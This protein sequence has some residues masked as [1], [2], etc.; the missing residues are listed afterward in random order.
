LQTGFSTK[1]FCSHSFKKYTHISR[2]LCH[3]KVIHYS[4]AFLKSS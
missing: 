3:A 1:Y 2:F 4:V